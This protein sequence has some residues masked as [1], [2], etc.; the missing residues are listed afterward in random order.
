MPRSSA[1]APDLGEKDPR[2]APDF[3]LVG[4]ADGLR[5]AVG[6]AAEA[7]KGAAVGVL[8]VFVE[9]ILQPETGGQNSN[10]V[11]LTGS[12]FG[13]W[14]DPSD[15]PPTDGPADRD[16]LSVGGRSDSGSGIYSGGPPR[17]SFPTDPPPALPTAPVAPAGNPFALSPGGIGGGGGGARRR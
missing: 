3:F 13:G 11:A 5:V 15:S 12:F 1:Q 4:A 14:T 7:F 9:P 16:P 17:P 10:G 2:P 6:G 8:E